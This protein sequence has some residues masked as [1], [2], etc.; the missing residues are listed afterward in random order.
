VTYVVEW[1]Q[2]AR[3]HQL[4]TIWLAATDR[5]AVTA[6]AH[7]IDDLLQTNPAAQGESRG[8]SHR[9]LLV[10][11]L[12]VAYKVIRKERRVIV[13]SVRYYRRP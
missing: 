7:L 3:E 12:A 8:K 2:N 9:I 11:P 1:T 6:A 4:A 13:F 10:K 5:R